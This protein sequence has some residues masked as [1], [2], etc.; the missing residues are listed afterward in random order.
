MPVEKFEL[1]PELLTKDSLPLDG[2]RRRCWSALRR[3][4]CDPNLAHGPVLQT[5]VKLSAISLVKP[6]PEVTNEIVRRLTSGDGDDVRQLWVAE[7]AA[8]DL[9]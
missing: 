3:I 1:I 2:R 8:D 9:R 5:Q 4:A 7:E 6:R